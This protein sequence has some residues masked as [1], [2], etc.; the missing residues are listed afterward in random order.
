MPGHL[1]PDVQ[2]EIL[3]YIQKNKAKL[4]HAEM[5]KRFGLS[6]WTIIR[7]YNIGRELGYWDRKPRPSVKSRLE[8]SRLEGES[9]EN[10]HS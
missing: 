7:Y 3:D 8:P 6:R 4:T 9:G 10:T 1:K 5:A 2:V